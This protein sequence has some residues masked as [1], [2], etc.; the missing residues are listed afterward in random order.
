MLPITHELPRAHV[1][2][3]L[4]VFTDSHIVPQGE[5][6]IG[7]NPTARLET[8]IA[9]VNRHHA[10]ADLVVFT[11]LSAGHIAEWRSQFSRA[12]RINNP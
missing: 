12:R 7:L 8:G 2:A 5:T 1:M 3:K 9:H 4:I 11:G 6:I 10:D